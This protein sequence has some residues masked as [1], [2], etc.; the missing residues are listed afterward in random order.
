MHRTASAANAGGSSSRS[1]R[2]SVS[3]AVASPSSRLPSVRVTSSIF[4]AL[5]SWSNA[6]TFIV[7]RD[8]ARN[9]HASRSRARSFVRS[10]VHS[11]VRSFVCSLVR[12]FVRSF[13]RGA[14]PAQ[15]VCL[16][17]MQSINS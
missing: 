9:I 4:Y 5:L 12:S 13:F 6:F 11:F 16:D 3:L 8:D 7:P 15:G 2:A 1:S 10:L 14:N 17:L